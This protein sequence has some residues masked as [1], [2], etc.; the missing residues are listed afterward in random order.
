[1]FFFFCF[2]WPKVY[3]IEASVKGAMCMQGLRGGIVNELA[4]RHG[5]FSAHE[6]PQ[7]TYFHQGDNG[8]VPI[9]PAVNAQEEMSNVQDAEA[10]A[11][12]AAAGPDANAVLCVKAYFYDRG[13]AL[14]FLASLRY[15]KRRDAAHTEFV[16]PERPALVTVDANDLF[17]YTIDHYVPTAFPS[18]FQGFDVVS[19]SSLPSAGLADNEL[20]E[21]QSLEDISLSI[22]FR[23]YRMHVMDK[24]KCVGNFATLANDDNNLIAGSVA[25]PPSI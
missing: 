21:Y 13:N 2:F 4:T 10:A 6:G 19:R 12:A 18:P 7:V 11:A 1:L 8:F 14:D 22:G 23:L 9:A 25:V 5:H 24:A 15:L 17:P 20:S 16:L 3:L